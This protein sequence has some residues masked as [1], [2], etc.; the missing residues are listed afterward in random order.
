MAAVNEAAR[1]VDEAMQ[2]K[3]G[4]MAGGLP[5]HVPLSSES[6][7]DHDPLARLIGELQR[8]PGIGPKTATRL[9]HHL[10]KIKPESARGLAEAILEVKETLSHCSTCNSITA[11]D[12]CALCTDPQRDRSRICVV[13]EP[14]NIQAIE[15][16]GEFHGLY[17]VAGRHAL[18][19]ARHRPR[20][21]RHRR[22]DRSPRRRR[23]DHPRHQPQRRGRGHRALPRPRPAPARRQGHAPRVRPAHRRRHRVHRRGHPRALPQRPQIALRSCPSL[24]AGDLAAGDGGAAA[25]PA[26]ARAERGARRSARLP[27]STP[28]RPDPAWCGRR[29]SARTSSTSTATATST[30]PRASASP[31]SATAIRAW[32]RRSREQA[33]TLRARSRRRRRASGARR[34][35]AA[36]AL[37]SR[38]CPMRAST[39]R[40]RARTRSRSRSKTALLATGRA[41]VLAFDPAYHGTSVGALARHLARRRSSRRS[42]P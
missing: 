5:G 10:L 32:W 18:A 39:S 28:S 6:S 26:L 37:R 29:R 17:H 21:A 11:V 22:P 24:G 27:A 20:P 7:S 15:R 33:S 4:G 34:A 12:P 31:R 25:G 41:G 38:R 16:T 30:S 2:S 42:P 9:A 14:F 3:I 40:C 13:E 1:K 19:A 23:G 36:A 35:G 8:L